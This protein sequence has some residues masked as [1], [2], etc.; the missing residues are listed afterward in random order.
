MAVR[1]AELAGGCI[2]EGEAVAAG[3]A[4]GVALPPA[5]VL[6]RFFDLLADVD[7]VAAEAAAVGVAGVAGRL[8]PATACSGEPT[9]FFCC[10]TVALDIVAALDRRPAAP[11]SPVPPPDRLG[12]PPEAVIVGPG[13]SMAMGPFEGD[14]GGL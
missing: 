2:I 12:V 9:E 14:M 3:P 5:W 4:P 1:S 7:G 13:R 8:R 11:P 10:R 6:L